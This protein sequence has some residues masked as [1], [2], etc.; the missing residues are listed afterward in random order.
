MFLQGLYVALL[1]WYKFPCRV[2]HDPGIWCD[3]VRSSL[4]LLKDR[5]FDRSGGCPSTAIYAIVLIRQSRLRDRVISP[6]AIYAS[7]LFCRSQF[8]PSCCF[9]D[10]N[11]CDRVIFSWSRVQT[12]AK[13]YDLFYWSWVR[14]PDQIACFRPVRFMAYVRYTTNCHSFNFI[15]R[16]ISTNF[17]A[18]WSV[19]DK[20]SMYICPLS[21]RMLMVFIFI[22]M[23]FLFIDVI[24]VNVISISIQWSKLLNIKINNIT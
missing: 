1:S 8:T 13:Q 5:I 9:V 20:S 11:L 15:I 23:E 24:N 4:D 19:R 17:L 21:M 12:L 7:V 6:I 10:C 2:L 14:F 16:R 18:R 3:L 22:D